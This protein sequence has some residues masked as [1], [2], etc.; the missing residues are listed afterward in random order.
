M[1]GAAPTIGGGLFQAGS[2]G[3]FRDPTTD[4]VDPAGPGSSCGDGGPGSGGSGDGPGGGG[5]GGGGSCGSSSG[6]GAGG[7]PW[8][9]GGSGDGA[10]DGV[11]RI[12]TAEGLSGGNCQPTCEGGPSG[13]GAN[14]G[15]GPTIQ[16]A[17]GAGGGANSGGGGFDVGMIGRWN[18]HRSRPGNSPARDFQASAQRADG[19]PCTPPPGGPVPAPVPN[20]SAP[21]SNGLVTVDVTASVQAAGLRIYC[22]ET[23]VTLTSDCG[24]V[25]FFHK[26]SGPSLVFHYSTPGGPGSKCTGPPPGGRTFSGGS[27]SGNASGMAINVTE[28]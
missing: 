2:G 15:W 8:G 12:F 4:S 3:G 19:L 23:G 10:G 24:S 7:G 14:S 5:S 25:Q 16:R 6:G 27:V 17:G 11:S 18:V 22:E 21:F 28:V 13:G 1:I 20:S 26:T 9:G